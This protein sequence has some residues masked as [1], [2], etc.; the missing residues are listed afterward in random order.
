MRYFQSTTGVAIRVGENAIENDQLVKTAHQDHV[1]CHLENGSSPHAVIEATS[2]DA[3]TLDQALQLV[4]HFSKGKGIQARMI[5]SK[6][7]DLERDRQKPGLVRLKKAPK[8]RS[9]RTDVGVL[10]SLGIEVKA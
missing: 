3:Q 1:W 7:R 2:P 6:I 4:K 5:I 9:I 10:R 8:K